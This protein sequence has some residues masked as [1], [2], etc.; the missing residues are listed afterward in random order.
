MSDWHGKMVKIKALYTED[1]VRLNEKTTIDNSQI[2]EEIIKGIYVKPN[3]M[4]LPNGILNKSPIIL[5]YSSYDVDQKLKMY[6][7]VSRKELQSISGAKLP[8]ELSA[9]AQDLFK[10][11]VNETNNKSV[12]P[13]SKIMSL[14]SRANNYESVDISVFYDN[15]DFQEKKGETQHMFKIVKYSENTYLVINS[16]V[17]FTKEL[18]YIPVSK[19]NLQKQLT[20]VE[21]KFYLKQGTLEKNELLSLQTALYKKYIS[22]FSKHGTLTE[23]ISLGTNPYKSIWENVST[24]KDETRLKNVLNDFHPYLYLTMLKECFT[25]GMTNGLDFLDVYMRNNHLELGV[26]ILIE[27][28]LYVVLFHDGLFLETSSNHT[29][30]IASEFPIAYLYLYKP[31]LFKTLSEQQVH[32]ATQINDEEIDIDESY[33]LISDMTKYLT[34]VPTFLKKEIASKGILT[35]DTIGGLVYLTGKYLLGDLDLELFPNHKKE[36]FSYDEQTQMVV[37]N[38]NIFVGEYLKIREKDLEKE[39]ED[40]YSF[41]NIQGMKGFIALLNDANTRFKGWEDEAV[42]YF[43]FSKY[44]VTDFYMSDYKASQNVADLMR[45]ADNS[46][47]VITYHKDFDEDDYSEGYEYYIR[48]YEGSFRLGNIEFNYE[49]EYNKA[50]ADY[51][52][53]DI[54]ISIKG[55]DEL[56]QVDKKQSDSDK[57]HKDFMLKIETFIK[58]L[59]KEELSDLRFIDYKGDTLANNIESLILDAYLE[60]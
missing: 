43:L 42:G 60:K 21:D 54:D 58:D 39:Y 27:D 26:N 32:L 7:I 4:T 6:P 1:G 40:V 48:E 51:T 35:V 22:E 10:H 24:Y 59:S 13:V 8:K 37:D 34:Q 9:L 5:G 36:R 38:D 20:Q 44:I 45:S 30:L 52:F 29:K 41:E 18:D 14:L 3:F 2:H 11:Y 50:S 15:Q 33:N 23:L 31:Y 57:T 55:E 46:F 17:S 49:L 16:L 12:S 19:E 53:K 28:H 25:W 56:D 47:D